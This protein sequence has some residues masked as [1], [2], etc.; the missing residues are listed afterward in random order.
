MP[1]AIPARF[2]GGVVF[3][4]EFGNDQGFTIYAGSLDDASRFHPTVA[5]LT[6]NRPSW[7][8]IL[9]L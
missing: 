8:V 1:C 6:R 3:A 4:G 5:R 2:C 7:A 9:S